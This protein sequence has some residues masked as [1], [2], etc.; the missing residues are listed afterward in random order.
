MSLSY[1]SLNTPNL[2]TQKFYRCKNGTSKFYLILPIAFS[3]SCCYDF[4]AFKSYLIS[5]FFDK[6][7]KK[8]VIL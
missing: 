4:R 2:E 3:E 5:K 1:I 8:T 6:T 7:H